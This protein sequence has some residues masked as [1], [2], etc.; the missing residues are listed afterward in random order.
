M[1]ANSKGKSMQ[2]PMEDNPKDIDGDGFQ[3]IPYKHNKV[4]MDQ[5]P[6]TCNRVHC[7]WIGLGCKPKVETPIHD[8]IRELVTWE[9]KE[10]GV[11]S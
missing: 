10:H 1:G 8:N 3:V 11:K 4:D 5:N 2:Q 9:C 6:S 7:S